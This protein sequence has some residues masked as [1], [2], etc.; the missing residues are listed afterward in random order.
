MERTSIESAR[1]VCPAGWHVPSSEEWK[2]LEGNVDSQYGVGHA[3]WDGSGFRGQDAG[4]KLKAT[5]GWFMGN[6]GSDDYG[7]AVLPSGF[8]SDAGSYSDKMVGAYIWTS[9]KLAR[10]LS[11]NNDKI[12]IIYESLDK[13][14][15][16]RCLKD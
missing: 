10:F 3:I 5:S 9:S 8:R 16:V 15:P 2:V 4:K 7:F 1:G 13:G 11:F 14:L 6:N 12:A